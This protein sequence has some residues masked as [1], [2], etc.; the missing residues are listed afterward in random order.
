MRPPPPPQFWVPIRFHAPPVSISCNPLARWRSLSITPVMKE[1]ELPHITVRRQR[2]EILGAN[3]LSKFNRSSQHRYSLCS[4]YNS[5]PQREV[6]TYVIF[7]LLKRYENPLNV[8]GHNKNSR[9][10]RETRASSYSQTLTKEEA[11]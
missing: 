6:G 3:L 8:F 9:V 1:T 10:V 2:L 4:A 7:L 11:T 5:T